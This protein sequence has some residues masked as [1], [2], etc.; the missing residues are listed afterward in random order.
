MLSKS[1]SVDGLTI[2]QVKLSTPATG[3]EG[4]MLMLGVD[5]TEFCTISVSVEVADN[6]PES[7]MVARHDI[8][9]LGAELDA[10]I[11]RLAPVCITAPLLF[12]HS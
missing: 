11:E 2:E 9:V 7:V 6:P 8:K 10:V 4:D 12:S 1:A 5:G 3:A